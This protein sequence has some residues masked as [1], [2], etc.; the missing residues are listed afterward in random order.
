MEFGALEILALILI[1]VAVVK[2]TII[3]LNPQAWYSLVGK[4]YFVPELISII[5]LFLSVAVL[6][7]IVSSG[8][9]IVEILAVC[10]F[11]LLLMLTGMAN[12]ADQI[13]GW[14]REQDI[15]YMVKRLW[16]YI[17]VWVFLIAWGIQALFFE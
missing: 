5:G 8:I 6:Y 4:I 7:F 14:V 16:L 17:M 12:Y 15:L 3:V 11:I 2:V 1:A 13:I 9:T 10:L